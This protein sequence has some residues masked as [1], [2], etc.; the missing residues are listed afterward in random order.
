MQALHGDRA[1]QGYA[2]PDNPVTGALHSLAIQYGYGEIWSRPGLGRR[3]CALL[4]VAAFSA[5]R[6]PDQVQKFGQSALNVGLTKEEVIEAVIQTA[7]YSGFPP[8]LNALA[9]LSAA[10]R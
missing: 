10:F 4:S 7:P 3:E 2:A 6:L 1:L 9:A 8:G 5:L